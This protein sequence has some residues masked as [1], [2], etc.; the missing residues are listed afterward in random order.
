[1]G[2]GRTA[3]AE[4]RAHEGAAAPPAVAVTS[5]V[6][7][8]L[9][10]QQSAGN[11]AVGRLLRST[12]RAGASLVHPGR[13]RMLMR[14]DVPTLAHPDPALPYAQ[15]GWIDADDVRREME[16][17][18]TVIRDILP[19]AQINTDDDVKGY[20][21]RWLRATECM[22]MAIKK[23]FRGDTAMLTRSRE[24]YNKAIDIIL[25]RGGV[26]ESKS[27]ADVRT[28][29]AGELGGAYEAGEVEPF[30]KGD[31]FDRLDPVQFP[32]GSFA[33]MVLL[34]PHAM[35]FHP[36]DRDYCVQNCPAAA[37]RMQE[38]LISG[39]LG[40]PLSCDPHNEPMDGYAI[41]PGPDTWGPARSWPATLTA[42]TAA[43]RQHGQQVIV[44]GDRGANHDPT[45]TQ[46][47]YF[48][49]ANIR[50]HL[51][52]LDAFTGEVLSDF[53]EYT[54]RLQTRTYK[55]TSHRVEAVPL[56]EWQ[57]RHP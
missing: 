52:I 19:T 23:Y 8:I 45:L 34:N 49:V 16:R 32:A 18:D 31:R 47:H 21:R 51:W 17:R 54:T 33:I 26:A 43:L 9:R 56:K 28:A 7:V 14:D 12:S 11:A 20:L 1:M 53:N 15:C 22:E 37:S 41:D 38:Y 2:A 35:R 46:W 10:L 36:Y 25:L 3:E 24:Q 40:P 48:C 42:I 4:A 39:R 55:F 29:H 50:G 27:A 30:T 13:G 57:R 6:Q 44:E 5:P